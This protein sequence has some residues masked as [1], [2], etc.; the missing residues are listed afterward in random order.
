[1]A[2]SLDKYLLQIT[3]VL[4][5]WLLVVGISCTIYAKDHSIG[6]FR[7]GPSKNLVFVGFVL[8]TWSKWTQV[9]VLVIVSQIIYMLTMESVSP[10]IMNTVMDPKTTQIFH[11][12]YSNIQYIC[13]TYYMFSAVVQLVQVQIVVAQADLAACIVFVDLIVSLITTHIF[14]TGKDRVGLNPRLE[15]T[16]IYYDE[17]KLVNELQELDS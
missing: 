8:D 3:H 6:Y 15:L 14:V 16:E 17:E 1:M 10:W 11:Y 7:I 5:V 2:I 13:N 9:V 4:V 12:S